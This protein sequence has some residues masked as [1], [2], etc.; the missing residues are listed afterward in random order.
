MGNAPERT[1]NASHP[2]LFGDYLILHLLNCPH[3]VAPLLL[4]AATCQCDIIA[5]HR[6]LI[7][8]PQNQERELIFRL[9]TSSQS[10]STVIRKLIRI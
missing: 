5:V 8:S 4:G 3:L 10:V 7:A 1:I 2:L 9:M 6:S